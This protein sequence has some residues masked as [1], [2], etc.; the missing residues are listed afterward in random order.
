M[1]ADRN[2]TT[3][4]SLVKHT[5]KTISAN[6]PYHHHKNKNLH[7]LNHSEFANFPSKAVVCSSSNQMFL[8]ISQISQENTCVMSLFNKVAGL[9][10]FEEKLF[11]QN[12]SS[13]CFCPLKNISSLLI[14]HKFK[15][16]PFY[17]KEQDQQ[18]LLFSC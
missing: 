17:T 3:T 12:T 7:Q 5:A 15:N 16:L 14:I 4:T 18:M 1:V 6:H 8:E 13:A 2:K 9:R 11:S 10:Y